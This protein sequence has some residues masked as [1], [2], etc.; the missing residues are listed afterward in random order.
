V[1]KR[2]GSSHKHI[3]L[4]VVVGKHR[5]KADAKLHSDALRLG[6]TPEDVKRLKPTRAK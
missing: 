3:E 6:F 4:G 2:A 1:I 5:T